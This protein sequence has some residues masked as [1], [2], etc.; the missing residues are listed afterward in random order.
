MTTYGQLLRFA[1]VGAATTV[2]YLGLYVVLRTG[3]GAFSANLIAAV[4]TTVLSTALHRRITFGQRPDGTA[5]WQQAQGLLLFGLNAALTSGALSSLSALVPDPGQ[6][7]ELAVLV[8]ATAVA[9]LLRFV[10]LRTWV[11]KVAAA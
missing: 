9:G 3:A 6:H 5:L 1:A 4:A 2:A 8:V 10:L 7:A 11:F